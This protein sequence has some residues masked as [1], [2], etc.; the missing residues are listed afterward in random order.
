MSPQH[1]VLMTASQLGQILQASRKARKLSQSAL[2]TKL[3]LSQSRVSHLEQHAQ[4]LSLEQLMAWCS[5]LGLELAVGTSGGYAS[6][7]TQTDW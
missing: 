4:E 1:Q 7:A 5:A 2:A 3:G 6:P